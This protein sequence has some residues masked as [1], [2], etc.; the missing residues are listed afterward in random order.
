[1]NQQPWAFA[2]S[3]DRKRIGQWSDQATAWLLANLP[4]T[5]FS[6]GALEILQRPGYT[7]FYHAPALVLVLAKSGGAQAS[8]DCC[9][10]AQ[11]LMLAARS[12]G[13]GTCWVGFARPWLEL[14]ATKQKLGIPKNYHVVAPIIV[15]VPKEWPEPHGRMPPEIHWLG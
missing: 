5:E 10:A 13:I 4:E 8:E 9:L 2:V 1:M 14:P 7:I 12:Q 11:N 6:A 15:G 3:L